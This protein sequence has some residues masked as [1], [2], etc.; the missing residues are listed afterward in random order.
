MIYELTTYTGSA[1]IGG[2]AMR[3]HHKYVPDCN[4]N[5][6]TTAKNGLLLSYNEHHASHVIENLRS[7]CRANPFNLV[8]EGNS[9]LRHDWRMLTWFIIL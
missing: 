2:A 3:C 4:P 1:V 6:G 5:H 7:Y 9:W 8:N